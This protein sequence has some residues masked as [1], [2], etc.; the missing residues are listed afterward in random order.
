M[1]DDTQ[2]K[3]Q[4]LQMLEQNLQN[5]LAQKQNFQ[6][7]AVE[8]D[9]AMEELSNTEQAYKIVGN[10]MVAAKKSDLEKEL[11]GKKEMTALRIKAVEKQEKSL[12]DRAEKIQKEIVGELK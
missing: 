10:L 3:I 11:Q 1:S 12:K 8:I 2:K 9:S 7:Q 5:F 6:M 4:E